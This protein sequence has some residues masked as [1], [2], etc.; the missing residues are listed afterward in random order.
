MQRSFL[1]LQGV[2]S[3]FFPRLADRLVAK[4]HRV[5]RIN[6]CAGDALYWGR[7]PAWNYGRPVSGLADFLTE[8]F[9]AHRFTDIVLFGDQR[10]VHRPA[11]A[12]AKAAGANVHVFEEGYLRPH[13]VTLE[14]GGANAASALP[15]DP[16]WYRAA[17]AAVPPASEP[18]RIAVPMA[19]RA[20]HDMAYHAANLANPFLFPG[21]RTH[22]PYVSAVEYAGWARRFSALP[23]ARRR[24]ARVIADLIARGVPYFFLPLQ[25]NADAQVARH[26]RYGDMGTVLE[27]V[28]SSF[29]AHAPAETKI[30]IKNHPLD[31]GLFPYRRVI[32]RLTK[33]LGLA[34]RVE[35]LETGDL[36]TLL[37]HTRGVVTVN[38][39]V[40]LAA[41]RAQRPTRTL[42]EAIY[43]LPGLTCQAPLD[44]FW[45]GPEP[46]DPALAAAYCAV[47]LHTTQVNGDFYTRGGIELAV[48]NS[49]PFL[50]SPSRLERLMAAVGDPSAGNARCSATTH[51]E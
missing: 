5:A 27:K 20:G 41:V 50:E 48:R 33:A 24:D 13:W 47:L 46:P 9:A 7:R 29:A 10:P 40:G 18:Q 17:A 15:R 8:K 30:A 34:G 28:L 19:V 31:T 26:S 44:A 16:A 36:A 4:G 38:S 32:G 43:D 25:L 21:Y 2:V 1:F 45:R 23:L 39:T 35:F 12:L 37:R 51:R 14:R 49:L 6:F 11:I 42:G 3:P 22:R